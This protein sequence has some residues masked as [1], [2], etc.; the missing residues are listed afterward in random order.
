MATKKQKKNTLT[1]SKFGEH[2][3]PWVSEYKNK[4]MGCVIQPSKGKLYTFK[5]PKI[6]FI[7]N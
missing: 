3:R 4:N 1:Y 7:I 2:T 5:N 6:T